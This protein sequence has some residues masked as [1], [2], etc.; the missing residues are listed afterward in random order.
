MSSLSVEEERYEGFVREV[1]YVRSEER[2]YIEDVGNNV[3]GAAEALVGSG[4]EGC[5]DEKKGWEGEV[6][7]CGVCMEDDDSEGEEENEEGDHDGRE[8]LQSGVDTARESV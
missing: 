3:A 4:D 6:C 7:D 1:E 2:E 5:E 8:V